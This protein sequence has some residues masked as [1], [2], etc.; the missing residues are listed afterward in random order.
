MPSTPA[1]RKYPSSSVDFGRPGTTRCARP[2]SA[3]ARL[4]ASASV[5][6]TGGRCRPR[7]RRAPAVQGVH[8]V[9]GGRRGRATAAA[10]HARGIE[11]QRLDQAN[12]PVIEAPEQQE[13]RGRRRRTRQSS[14]RATRTTARR[15]TLAPRVEIT[16]SQADPAPRCDNQ[17]VEQRERRELDSGVSRPCSARYTDPNTAAQPQGWQREERRRERRPRSGQAATTGTLNV[18]GRCD[19]SCA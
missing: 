9:D 3:R 16:S 4:S 18:I 6:S 15:R 7:R 17:D 2:M 13:R 10:C 12:P 14:G 1:R 11:R 8:A 5:G 19:H